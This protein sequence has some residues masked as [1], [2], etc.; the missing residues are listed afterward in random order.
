MHLWFKRTKPD[1]SIKTSFD[2]MEE[3]LRTIHYPTTSRLP[4]LLRH[5][6][7]WKANE[8]RITILFGYKY[9]TRILIIFVEL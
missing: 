8:F 4:R 3:L 5:Y 7:L 6:K 1:Y 2:R 9:T